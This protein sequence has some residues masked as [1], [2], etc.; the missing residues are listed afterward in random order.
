MPSPI[1]SEQWPRFVLP[2]VRK[3]WFQKMTA[4]TSPVARFYGVDTS[5]NPVEYSQGIGD[6]GLI[7]EYNANV[8]EG[9]PAAIQ[10]GSFNPLFETTFTHKEYAK[11][12]AI[13]RKL[14]DDDQRG[15]IKRR[16]ANLGNAAGNTIAVHQ[17]SVFNY[18]FS[19]TAGHLGAD[20][21]A[22]C[23]ATHDNSPTDGTHVVNRG[24]SALAYAAIIATQQAGLSM[25]ADD[26]T[27]M[28]VVYDTLLV[29][30]ALGAT[31]IE[32]TRGS[33]KPGQADLTP[34][35]LTNG[36]GNPLTIVV[37]PYLTDANNWFML[38]STQALLHLLWYWRVRPE[39]T[40][41]PASDF[42][43]V[44]K[45]RMYMRYSFGWD[46]WRW[47]YGHEVT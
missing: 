32:E 25:K 29:P 10:Y 34:S 28:P 15:N 2:I 24:T 20:S 21:V 43:L 17:S 19:A 14:W 7:P 30:V 31:A 36:G 12:L 37:D 8:G 40:L 23:S 3:E 46:D 18:A 35:A 47:I 11:G 22:L 1:T 39:T 6:T 26:G 9:G 38:D 41:D 33:F 27:P 44:A 13:E 16:A 45:Y 5:T 42:N 4:V